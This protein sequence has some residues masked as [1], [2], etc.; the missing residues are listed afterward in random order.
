MFVSMIISVLLLGPT[1]SNAAETCCR[2]KETV[3]MINV[4]FNLTKIEIV[5]YI[6]KGMMI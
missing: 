2:E 4:V 6:H 5:D 1:I 3:D